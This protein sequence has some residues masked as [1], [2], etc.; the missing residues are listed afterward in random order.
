[1]RVKVVGIGG[2]GSHIIEPIARLLASNGEDHILV[3]LDGD[4]I[5]AKN[6]SRQAFPANSVGAGKA[7]IAAAALQERF[8]SDNLTIGYDNVY[9][10]EKNV[11]EYIDDGDWVVLCVDNHPTRRIVSHHCAEE[12]ANVVLISGGNNVIVGGVEYPSLGNCQTYIRI[13]GAHITDPLHANHPEIESPSEND[14]HPNAKSCSEI[15]AEG[16]DEVPQTLASN[17][18]AANLMFA[19][20]STLFM[21]ANNIGDPPK[22]LIGESRFDAAKASA[23]AV[24][25]R[26]AKGVKIK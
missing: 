20:F 1:M 25:Y 9:L 12:I 15:L 26:D 19:S 18:F 11:S 8:G 22:I 7:Q 13:D 2:I 24:F 3:L 10:D 14:L 21:W 17:M 16:G 6:L 23:D 5:E 4:S